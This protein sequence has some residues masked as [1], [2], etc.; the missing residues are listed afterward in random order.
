[1]EKI[2]KIYRYRPELDGLRFIA[3][4][5][6][7]LYH[8]KFSFLG[9]SDWFSGGYIGVDI[10]FV[11]SGFL[12]TNSIFKEIKKNKYFDFLNFYERRLR[13]ILPILITVL[14]VST[15]LA[16]RILIFNDLVEFG[17]SGIS[18]FLFVS[19]YFFHNVTSKYGADSSLL[20][21]LSYF[22]CL[23]KFNFI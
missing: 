19:N 21:P 12:I 16:W 1:M 5:S 15:V 13:R 8:A 7:L 6:V 10:F 2:S 17:R 3:I 14:A 9:K 18:T 20:K 4:I 23:L 22:I 11:L